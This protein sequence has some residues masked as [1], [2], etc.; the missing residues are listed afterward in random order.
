MGLE[1]VKE[2]IL[3]QAKEQETAAIAEARREAN[4]LTRET[5]KK[6]EEMKVKSEAETK[7]IIDVM[8]KQALASAELESKKMVLEAKKHVIDGVFTEIKRKLENLD[9]KKREYLIKALLEKT[10]KELDIEYVYCNKKDARFLKGINPEPINII[11]GVLAENKEKTIRVDY[12]FETLLENIK[13]AE[14][15]SINKILFG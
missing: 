9:E 1:S 8:K 3:R 15:Q 10:K 14:M 2:E 11:G 12:S 7:K 4:K 5:E 6:I 13:E